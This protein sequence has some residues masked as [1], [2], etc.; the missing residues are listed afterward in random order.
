MGSEGVI[1]PLHVGGVHDAVT[2][3]APIP[4]AVTV[5]TLPN[6]VLLLLPVAVTETGLLELH[7]RG[8]PVS[9]MPKISV[10]VAFKVVEV[11]VL[12]TNEVAGSPTAEMLIDCTG[13][14]TNCTGVLL[15]PLT[16]ARKKFAPGSLAVAFC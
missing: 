12:T 16:L 4:G 1:P 13:Q 3:P 8:T 10:T 11:E 6:T 15:T 5:P 2:D 14:V 9:V 7:V